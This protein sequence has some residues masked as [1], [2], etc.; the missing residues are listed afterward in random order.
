MAA[1]Q[2]VKIALL[3]SGGTG[4]TALLARYQTNE[5]D[6]LGVG[7][8]REEFDPMSRINLEVEQRRFVKKEGGTELLIVD[9]VGT[10]DFGRLRY[11][12]LADVDVFLLCYRVDRIDSFISISQQWHP[13]AIHYSKFD[14]QHERLHEPQRNQSR[15]ILVGLKSDLEPSPMITPEMIAKI[16]FKGQFSAALTC[17]AKTGEGVHEIFLAALKAS[18]EPLPPKPHSTCNLL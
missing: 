3:G 4:K 12:Q 5:F 17:S 16:M 6:P 8:H 10:S 7:R 13:N 15:F 11:E 9:T 18:H 14:T 1:D 2:R